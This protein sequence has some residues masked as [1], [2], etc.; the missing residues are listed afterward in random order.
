[1]LFDGV[2]ERLADLSGIGLVQPIAAVDLEDDRASARVELVGPLHGQLDQEPVVPVGVGP[3]RPRDRR[4]L[5][6]GHPVAVLRLLR[7]AELDA[8]VVPL[9]GEPRRGRHGGLHDGLG[10]LEVFLQQERRDG[11]DVADVVEAVAGI[12]GREL[13]L[14]LEVD[15][16]QVADRVV[17]LDAIEPADRH[18]AR[19]RIRGID[20]EDIVLDPVGQGLDFPGGRL[21]LAGR[22]HDPRADVLEHRPPQLAT[23]HQ[24]LV[25]PALIEG[26]LTL[27]HPVGVTSIAVVDQDRLD[28]L[29]EPRDGP[30]LTP[31]ARRAEGPERNESGDPRTQ[32]QGR[33]HPTGRPIHPTTQPATPDIK[34]I[35]SMLF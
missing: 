29:L 7:P 16:H 21:R 15:P 24:G 4:G 11:E 19:V 5:R 13:L 14:R 18:P 34:R 33:R 30:A 22:G 28:G 17:V 32:P 9:G 3:D 8:P 27:L 31:L 1:M 25:R 10:R 20:V 26:D 2:P 12:V 23:L 6:E 35:S